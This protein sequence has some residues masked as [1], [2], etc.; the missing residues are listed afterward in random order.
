MVDQKLSWS[1]QLAMQNCFFSF[2]ILSVLDEIM[3]ASLSRWDS[4][5]GAVSHLFTP[6]AVQW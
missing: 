2:F 5:I 3:S 4:F 1:K 6:T